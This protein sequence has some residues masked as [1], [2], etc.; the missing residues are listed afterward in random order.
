V[1]DPVIRDP[2]L[3]GILRAAMRAPANPLFAEALTSALAEALLNGDPSAR[4]PLRERPRLDALA[5]AWVKDYLDA[6]CGRTVRSEELERISGLDR[7]TLARQFRAAHGT[8]PYRYAQM[9]RLD[10]ARSALEDGSASLAA[11][12]AEAGYADQAHLTR[13]FK[14]TYGMTPGRYR[15]LRSGWAAPPAGLLE[16]PPEPPGS[17]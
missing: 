8:S 11:L 2:A 10:R 5:L 9:R 16:A 12:A 3:A 17:R 1:P 7:Y 15:A 6:E 14:A 4:G 13:R